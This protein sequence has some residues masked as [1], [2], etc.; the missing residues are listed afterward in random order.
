MFRAVNEKIARRN[1]EYGQHHGHRQA[2]DTDYGDNE[3][4]NQDEIGV[5]N[6]K[7]RHIPLFA[8][9]QRSA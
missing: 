5:S 9:Q 6:Y 7:S 1:Q 3:A 4:D 8:E 2:G